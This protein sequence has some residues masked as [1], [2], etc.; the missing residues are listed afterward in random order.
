LSTKADNE[1]PF[2]CPHIKP[3]R[4]VAQKYWCGVWHCEYHTCDECYPGHVLEHHMFDPGQ[5]MW[6]WNP[7]YYSA[8]IRHRARWGYKLCT[9]EKLNY[10]TGAAY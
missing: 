4:Q 1:Q 2:N 8:T 6:R 5:T 7:E 9:G 3:D 10:E